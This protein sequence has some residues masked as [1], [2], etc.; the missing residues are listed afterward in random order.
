MLPSEELHEILIK[1]IIPEIEE[2]IDERF[3]KIAEAKNADDEDKEALAELQSLLEDFKE[4]L[5]D[6]Q[7]GEMEE[8]ECQEIIDEL[9][10]M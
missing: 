2:S 7:S 4:M 3:A 5:T 6:L 9:A 10:T 8:D 1:G